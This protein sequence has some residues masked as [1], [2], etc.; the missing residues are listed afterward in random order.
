MRFSFPSFSN[1]QDLKERNDGLCYK[2]ESQEPFSGFAYSTK[3]NEVIGKKKELEGEN[4]VEI[5]KEGVLVSWSFFFTWEESWFYNPNFYSFFDSC[6]WSKDGVILE[7]DSLFMTCFI[8]DGV[9]G[10][11]LAKDYSSIE[12]YLRFP[13]LKE[14]KLYNF[15]KD[16]IDDCLESSDNLFLKAIE[17]V[18]LIKNKQLKSLVYNSVLF[19]A[20]EDF[21]KRNFFCGRT[22]VFWNRTDYQEKYIQNGKLVKYITPK[23]ISSG[24]C[25][26]NDKLFFKKKFKLEDISRMYMKD[27]VKLFG[28]T[29]IA[30]RGQDFNNHSLID[31]WEWDIYVLGFYG[32]GWFKNLESSGIKSL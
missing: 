1:I 15:Y 10:W 28:V 24:K 29:N 22:D 19:Q 16:T 23:C 9:Y 31:A 4:L 12:I 27:Y 30:I 25:F 21:H 13:S 7:E 8:E 2:K 17:K 5:Y 11:K 6:D 18:E 20:E 14:I 32:R 26:I 3:F